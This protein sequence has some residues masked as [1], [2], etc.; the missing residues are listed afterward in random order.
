MSPFVLLPMLQSGALL[1]DEDRRVM[2][3]CLL[4]AKAIFPKHPSVSI[5][6]PPLH[7]L[8]P[9][10]SYYLLLLFAGAKIPM[11]EADLVCNEEIDPSQGGGGGS[12]VDSLNAA[13]RLAEDSIRQAE[14]GNAMP[15]L[16][17]GGLLTQNV[18]CPLWDIARVWNPCL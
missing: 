18:S 6:L 10:L 13:L 15:F 2:R 1:V 12:D 11:L 3:D 5:P 17:K 7:L 8:P 4:G 9:T 14:P 16:V